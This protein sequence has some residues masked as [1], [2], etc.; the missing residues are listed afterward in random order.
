MASVKY[1][2]IY[3]CIYVYIQYSIFCNCTHHSLSMLLLYLLSIITNSSL[4]I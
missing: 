1:V 2:S 4:E 3:L